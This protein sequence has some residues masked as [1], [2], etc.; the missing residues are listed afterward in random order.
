[1]AV[2]SYSALKTRAVSLGVSA[3]VSPHSVG[4]DAQHLIVV[5]PTLFSFFMFQSNHAA[6]C[7]CSEGKETSVALAWPTLVEAK[8]VLRSA[9][10]FKHDE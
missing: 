4:V 7:S 3:G 8:D 5:R 6:C 1:M 10:L 2:R 9:V